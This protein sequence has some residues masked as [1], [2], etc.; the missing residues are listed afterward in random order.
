MNE[1]VTAHAPRTDQR[2]GREWFGE[3]E[4][5]TDIM[6]QRELHVGKHGVGSGL[7]FLIER[8]EKACTPAAVA[9][10]A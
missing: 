2:R 10:R 9:A 3:V 5:A 1:Y 8:A 7:R 6:L 4:H